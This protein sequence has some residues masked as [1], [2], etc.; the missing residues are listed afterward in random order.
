MKTRRQ[1][2]G[3]TR[4]VG[5]IFNAARAA[6]GNLKNGGGRVLQCNQIINAMDEQAFK[7]FKGMTIMMGGEDPTDPKYKVINPL[8]T[9]AYMD[10]VAANRGSATSQIAAAA[11]AAE[12]QKSPGG[13]DNTDDQSVEQNKSPVVP[14]AAQN[15]VE[16]DPTDEPDEPDEPD[17]SA[18][19]PA[20]AP[21]AGPPAEQPAGNGDVPGG[22]KEGGTRKNKRNRI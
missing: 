2:K 13:Q 1:R 6:I 10:K 17:E 14:A 5:G 22:Q 4:R 12:K 11:Q 8:P 20:S 16:P 21:E 7:M 18:G 15:K 9:S 19:A 3:G